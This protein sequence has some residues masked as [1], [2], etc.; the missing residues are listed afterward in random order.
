MLWGF[1]LTLSSSF[2]GEFGKVWLLPQKSSSEFV[3][4]INLEVLLILISVSTYLLLLLQV[5]FLTKQAKE[6]GKPPRAGRLLASNHSQDR[7]PQLQVKL[8]HICDCCVAFLKITSH[9]VPE[10]VQCYNAV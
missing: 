4:E 8:Q 1:C 2:L 6:N 9:K 10:C 5:C 3:S 7:F